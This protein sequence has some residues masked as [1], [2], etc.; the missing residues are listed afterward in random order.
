MLDFVKSLLLPY[1]I[2]MCSVIPLSQ[3]K[4]IR[5]YLLE[6]NGIKNGSAFIFAVP[7]RS[8]KCD[9]AVRN[10]SVYACAKDY[11]FFFGKL[12]DDILPALKDKYPENIFCAFSDHSPI[13][14]ADAASRSGLG[15]I[16]KN[17]L[18]ITKKYS[19]FIFLGEIITDA[20]IPCNASEPTIC[21]ECGRCLSACPSLLNIS[22]C[23][24]S[25]TQRKGDLTEVE[26]EYIRE[27]GCYWGCDICQ[28]VCP[29]TEKAIKEKTIYS[30]I[31]FFNEDLSPY[32]TSEF[33]NSLSD[34]QFKKRAY[35]WRGRQTILRNLEIAESKNAGEAYSEQRRD[36][37]DKK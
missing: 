15:V 9:V 10:I 26:K 21:I 2:D 24:S 5:P 35:S 3:C 8:E 19:S 30:K 23:L 20:V 11:H 22:D 13:Y 25:I 36:Q 27:S 16:G 4:V 29:Y 18:L 34:D 6:K 14:E 37:K 31:N 33:I 1:G 17:H 32:I 12:F 28:N 7:Y